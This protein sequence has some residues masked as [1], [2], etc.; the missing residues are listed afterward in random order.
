MPD[1]KRL[2]YGAII[3]AGALTFACWP[4]QVGRTIGL[5]LMSVGGWAVALGG[6]NRFTREGVG[7]GKFRW[8]NWRTLVGFVLAGGTLISFTLLFATDHSSPYALKFVY[9]SAVLGLVLLVYLA[10]VLFPGR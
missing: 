4:T 8:P 7:P 10:V 5:A 1:S 6:G 2:I 3:L 9:L